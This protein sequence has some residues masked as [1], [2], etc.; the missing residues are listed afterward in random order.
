RMHALK[1]GAG[2]Y[3]TN[4]DRPQPVIPENAKRFSGTFL[5]VR[6]LQEQGPGYLLRKFRDDM[7]GVGESA[8]C[9]RA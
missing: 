1:D 7:P 9:V 3:Q 6:A 4:S 2:R 5:L 8:R